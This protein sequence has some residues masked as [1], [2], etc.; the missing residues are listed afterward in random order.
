MKR[1][2]TVSILL[3]LIFTPLYSAQPD[4]PRP[5]SR[6]AILAHFGNISGIGMGFRYQ[7]YT[8]ASG[9]ILAGAI[10]P[11]APGFSIPYDGNEFNILIRGRVFHPRGLY[12]TA[13]WYWG[14]FNCTGFQDKVE[15]TKAYLNNGPAFAIGLEYP[16]QGQGKTLSL[17]FGTVM[18]LPDRLFSYERDYQGSFTL[19]AQ[20]SHQGM[21][22]FFPF[23]TLIL[24]L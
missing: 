11:F 2:L 6:Y 1:V 13:G 24:K 16:A 21:G 23:L 15:I 14:Y 8:I 18:G 5:V 3:Q 22:D 20:R 9:E 12:L 19:E 4:Q 7:F 10:G 17:E